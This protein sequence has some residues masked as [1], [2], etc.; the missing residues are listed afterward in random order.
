MAALLVGL[1]IM[2]V[3]MGMALPTWSHFMKR[4]REEELI[5]RGQQYAR[6][7]GLFQRRYANT[8][9]PTIDILVEQRFLR[10]KYKDPITNDDFQPIPA[11]T[12]ATP[13]TP[14][15]SGARP[16]Q[17][18]AQQPPP[19]RVGTQTQTQGFGTLQPFRVD[20][21]RAFRPAIGI[22]G[23]VSKSK[24]TSIK[25][26]NG[27][28]KYNEWAFVYLATSQRIGPAGPGPPQ[29]GAP[30]MQR[31]GLGPQG[32]QGT[33]PPVPFGGS[34]PGAPPAGASP[35]GQPNPFSPPPT[36][37]PRPPG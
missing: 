29:P 14:P 15:V 23:V 22:Q 32:P 13:I 4:E 26:Y 18:P 11:G 1:S 6:A 37:A 3:L 19:S 5:W 36:G 10:K 17:P 33:R 21:S 28:T 2:A 30:G 16:G 12:A 20:D 8:F 7:V 9:P 31:P 24:A 27:R 34:R 25:M 35:S